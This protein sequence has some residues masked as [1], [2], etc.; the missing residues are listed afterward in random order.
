MG[1]KSIMELFELCQESILLFLEGLIPLGKLLSMAV[2][3]IA[4][5]LAV[6]LLFSSELVSVPLIEPRELVG[7]LSQ[8]LIVSALHVT[9]LGVPLFLSLHTCFSQVCNV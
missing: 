5:L 1:S 8:V 9:P 4:H 2:T 7:L 3:Q 6:S